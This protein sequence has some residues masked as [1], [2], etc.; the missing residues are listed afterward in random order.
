MLTCDV[1]GL[2]LFGEL[3][4]GRAALPWR[5]GGRPVSGCI[6]YRSDRWQQ[7]REV[8][9]REAVFLSEVSTSMLVCKHRRATAVRDSSVVRAVNTSRPCKMAAPLDYGFADML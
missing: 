4:A 5:C 8:H 2:G 9:L 7:V 1:C 3:C 6:V